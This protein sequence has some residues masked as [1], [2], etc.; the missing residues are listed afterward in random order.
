MEMEMIIFAPLTYPAHTKVTLAF[1]YDPWPNAS[2]A[3]HNPKNN[4][5]LKLQEAKFATHYPKIKNTNGVPLVDFVQLV[6]NTFKTIPLRERIAGG[7]F[8]CDM[9][10]YL[11]TLDN[12]A[13][14]VRVAEECS[15]YK[16]SLVKD[17]GLDERQRVV[18]SKEHRDKALKAHGV[19]SEYA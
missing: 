10:E 3:S 13:A 12:F 9:D 8:G 15:L 2:Y 4:K 1:L 5:P 18:K 17:E 11:R 19:V 7:L 14:N 16:A 6:S